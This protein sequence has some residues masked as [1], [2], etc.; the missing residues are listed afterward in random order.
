MGLIIAKLYINNID[1][2]DEIPVDCYNMKYSLRK[3]S[4][5]QLNLNDAHGIHLTFN[6]RNGKQTIDIRYNESKVLHMSVREGIININ[7]KKLNVLADTLTTTEL[8]WKSDMIMIKIEEDLD[9][10]TI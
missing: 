6:E 5:T 8:S 1:I 7:F 10:I 2:Y 3:V 4:G 9:D